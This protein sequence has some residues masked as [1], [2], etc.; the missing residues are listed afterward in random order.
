MR[1]ELFPVDELPAGGGIRQVLVDKTKIAV[2][3]TPDGAVHALNDRCPH[4]GAQFSNG[5]VVRRLVAGPTSGEYEVAEGA[6]VVLCPHHG[7]E[8]NVEDGKCPADPTHTR[9]KC[10]DVSVEDGMVVLNK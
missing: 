5:G 8:F 9:V 1:H 3:R 4:Q 10:Y 7:F 2:V 6:Y